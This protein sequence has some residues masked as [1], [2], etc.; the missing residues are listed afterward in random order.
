MAND[1]SVYI[2]SEKESLQSPQM[3]SDEL[4]KV[5][6]TLRCNQL[7]TYPNFRLFRIAIRNRNGRSTVQGRIWGF[8]KSKTSNFAN[9][10]MKSKKLRH[11]KSQRWRISRTSKNPAKFTSDESKSRYIYLF[12]N[13]NKHVPMRLK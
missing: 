13:I 12:I 9:F 1:S 5:T 10:R 6:A 4:S 8:S 7:I 2:S 3:P 11:G